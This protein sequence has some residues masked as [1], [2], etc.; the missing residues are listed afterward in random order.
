MLQGPLDLACHT[1][2]GLI[3]PSITL[4]QMHLLLVINTS[5]QHSLQQIPIDFTSFRAQMGSL[6]MPQSTFWMIA[7][8][9]QASIGQLWAKSLKML[10][11]AGKFIWNLTT[12][13]IMDSLGSNN[14]ERHYLVTLCLTRE[15]SDTLTSLTS[16]QKILRKEKSPKCHS[17]LV[18]PGYRNTPATTQQTERRKHLSSLRVFK[19]IQN[20]MRKPL[21][22]STMM[23]E[24]NSLTMCGHQHH[25]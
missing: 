3:C 11:L 17:L 1:L 23:K 24:A 13:M 18:Q 14:T 22:S 12:L 19:L 8:P 21:L 10:E 16:S 2:T 4:L 25:Q 6:L 20:Y 9:K 15:W 5:N 7:N